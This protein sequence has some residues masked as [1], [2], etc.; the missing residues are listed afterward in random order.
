MRSANAQT[1]RNIEFA[2]RKSSLADGRV[3]RPENLVRMAQLQAG[4]RVVVTLSPQQR[5]ALSWDI[6]GLSYILANEWLEFM[7]HQMGRW[8]QCLDALTT[9]TPSKRRSLDA[10]RRRMKQRV[11]EVWST[12]CK[13]S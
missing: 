5:D 2:R 12:E 10:I 3:V 13:A 9:L 7:A 8:Q 6:E 11:A 1:K 4:L